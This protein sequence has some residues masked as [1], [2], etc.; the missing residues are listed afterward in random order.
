VLIPFIGPMDKD[1]PSYLR[2]NPFQGGGGGDDEDPLSP[3]HVQGPIHGPHASQ[4]QSQPR[5]P[6]KRSILKKIQMS[7]P[8]NG[9]TS[10]GL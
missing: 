1:A 5:G 8:Q 7:F 4:A 3:H 6:I 9:H 2:T 10:H